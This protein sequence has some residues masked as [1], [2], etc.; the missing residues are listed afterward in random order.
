M[1]LARAASYTNAGTV[2]FLV[3]AQRNFYFLEVNTRL[4]VEHPVTESVTGLDLVKL[5]MRIAAGEPLAVSR[6]KTSL[7]AATPS[8][9]AS[10][11]KTRTI[12]SFLRPGKFCAGA[13]PPA[14]AFAWTRASMPAGPC[15]A[16]TIRCS[17][18]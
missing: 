11:P 12:I 2:E 1:N 18:N 10:M 4:Q 15:R 13:F 14:P 5:Q 9:A 3:D 8:S 6:R 7:C 17:A 16:I